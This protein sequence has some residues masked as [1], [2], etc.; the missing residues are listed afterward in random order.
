M[1]KSKTAWRKG[2]LLEGG[3]GA[4]SRLPSHWRL[5]LVPSLQRLRG[6]GISGNEN[7]T[8]SVP[9]RPTD[10]ART[11]HG[12]C[13]HCSNSLHLV[14]VIYCRLPDRTELFPHKVRAQMF[15]NQIQMPFL[16]NCARKYRGGAHSRK[17]PATWFLIL[18]TIVSAS[19]LQ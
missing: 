18:V 19:N 13:V 17:L 16:F 11:L 1:Y 12:L 7:A 4:N 9:V 14:I 6:P 3:G 10:F 8:L 5:V 15:G 2:R